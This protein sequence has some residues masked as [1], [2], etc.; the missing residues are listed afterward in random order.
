MAASKSFL[1]FFVLWISGATSLLADS[2][3]NSTKDT[4]P[5]LAQFDLTLTSANKVEVNWSMD[6]PGGITGFYLWRS[7]S[8]AGTDSLGLNQ[9]QLIAPETSDQ[10]SYVYVDESVRPQSYYRYWLTVV[11][12]TGY[13]ITCTP[14]TIRTGSENPGTTTDALAIPG[15]YPNPFNL[16]TTISYTLATESNVELK[17]TDI[18][19]RVVNLLKLGRQT[20]GAHTCYWSGFDRAGHTPP[21]GVY[22]AHI[23]SGYTTATHKLILCK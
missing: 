6:Y 20:A 18:R 5:V 21:S 8:M 1:L 7:S 17:I 14:W 3:S 4:L 19:G 11:Y 13:T 22:L 16:G 10:T 9:E 23:K 15:N 12:D 2:V